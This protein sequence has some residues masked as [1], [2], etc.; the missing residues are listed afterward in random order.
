MILFTHKFFHLKRLFLTLFDT[1]G[2]YYFRMKSQ[3]GKSGKK[4]YNFVLLS[5][6]HEEITF[7]HER[8]ADFFKL[9]F[10]WLPHG[11]L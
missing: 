1:R 9:L 11:Q 4:A 3:S 7:T 10:T 2:W 6:K 8:N 5:S